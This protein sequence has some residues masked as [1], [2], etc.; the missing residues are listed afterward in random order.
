MRYYQSH[1]SGIYQ[2]SHQTGFDNR[3]F[4][5]VLINHYRFPEFLRLLEESDLSVDGLT[6]ILKIHT[7]FREFGFSQFTI[8]LRGPL[9][10]LFKFRLGNRKY[11]IAFRGIINKNDGLVSLSVGSLRLYNRFRVSHLLLFEFLVPLLDIFFRF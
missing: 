8:L 4:H 2:D 7:E 5:I 11:N 1:N 6:L 3:K 9:P 10:N